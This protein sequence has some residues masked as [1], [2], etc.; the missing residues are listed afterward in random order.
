MNWYCSLLPTV[1]DEHKFEYHVEVP[2]PNK[3]NT[4]IVSDHD[5]EEEEQSDIKDNNPPV[6]DGDIIREKLSGRLL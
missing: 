4:V 3:Q 5:L 2:S 6:W 1:L